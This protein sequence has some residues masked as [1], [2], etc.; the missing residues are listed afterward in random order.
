MTKDP[1]SDSL[2]RESPRALA[3]IL[4]LTMVTACSQPMEE[5]A[6]PQG[7]DGDGPVQLQTGCGLDTGLKLPD[8]SPQIVDGSTLWAEIPNADNPGACDFY[9]FAMNNFLW[10]VDTGD[11]GSPR[12][13]ENIPYTA[14]FPEEGE[15]DCQL[16][17]R[18]L[19]PGELEKNQ[20]GDNFQLLDVTGAPVQYDVRMNPQFCEAIS[21]Q[22][23]YTQTGFD[24][25]INAFNADPTSGGIWLPAGNAEENK[26]GAMI[27]KTAWRDYGKTPPANC[28]ALIHCEETPDGDHWGLI[29]MHMVQKTPS[30][31]EFMW[32]SYEHVANAPDCGTGGTNPIAKQPVNPF[33]PSQGLNI[34][35]GL[36]IADQTGWALFNWTRYQDAGGD[37]QTC[38]SPTGT[39]VQADPGDP[40]TVDTCAMAAGPFLCNTNPQSASD[41]T[42]FVQVD[43]CRT[44]SL[45]AQSDNPDDPSVCGGITDLDNIA[46]L[47]LS[48]QESWPAAIPQKWHTY[49]QIGAVWMAQVDTATGTKPGA[50]AVGCFNYQDPPQ[51]KAASATAL[52]IP[53]G[54]YV[55]NLC[56]YVWNDYHAGEPLP[57]F[58]ELTVAGIIDLA[59]T[60]METWMQQSLCNNYQVMNKETEQ[61]QPTAIMQQDCFSC[62]FPLTDSY[63][64]GDTSHAFM[65]VPSGDS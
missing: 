64:A 23:V 30:H 54:Y 51:H 10:A 35:W 19:D 24:A 48:L 53:A 47:N 8:G 13:M 63:G 55:D 33:D 20:A 46:C 31:G 3:A 2:D 61:Y 25:A 28:N 27:I 60:T 21:Q 44:N 59:S 11:S 16:A 50:P 45:P 62:H 57:D 56:T 36:D 37:G 42:S 18:P 5:L 6:E 12:F 7:Y 15:P 41:P 26:A 40:T 9:R 32:S 49:F 22:N 43:V 39:L 17:A 38:S 1:H 58:P 65:H 4:M 29:G 34:N 14:A 52:G